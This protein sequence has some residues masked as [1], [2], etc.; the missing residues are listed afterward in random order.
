MAMKMF[1]R[2]RTV[3]LKSL[4]RQQGVTNQQLVQEI[5]HLRSEVDQL[6]CSLRLRLSSDILWKFTTYFQSLAGRCSEFA[7]RRDHPHHKVL[8]QS[9]ECLA[10][11]QQVSLAAHNLSFRFERCARGDTAYYWSEHQHAIQQIYIHFSNLVYE[12]QAVVL[13][14][15]SI[16]AQQPAS[17]PPAPAT[18]LSFNRAS[19]L[20]QTKAALR[21]FEA[22]LRWFGEFPNMEFGQSHA[23]LDLILAD[24]RPIQRFFEWSWEELDLRDVSVQIVYLYFDTLDSLREMTEFVIRVRVSNQ[25]TRAQTEEIIALLTKCRDQLTQLQKHTATNTIAFSIP[26]TLERSH[27]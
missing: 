25:G 7:Q 21:T 18:L 20:S 2:R 13:H 5:E 19:L 23:V 16:P 27:G 26:L 12:L 3:A 24:I 22:R 9:P 14:A 10:L 6:R 17:P 1:R 11:M 4:H 8:A 15:P